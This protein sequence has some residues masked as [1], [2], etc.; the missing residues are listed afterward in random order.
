MNP[1]KD[2]KYRLYCQQLSCSVCVV[3]VRVPLLPW[4]EREPATRPI[5]CRGISIFCHIAINLRAKWQWEMNHL[6]KSNYCWL[7]WL[8][9]NRV[10]MQSTLKLSE[11]VL[12]LAQL[13][14]VCFFLLWT[15]R[16]RGANRVPSNNNTLP[17]HQ[18]AK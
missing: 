16:S 14:S 17:L 11:C 6:C 4:L 18:A 9:C 13:D 10:K 3:V 5:H 12:L 15:D 1:L 8:N 2:E 7:S